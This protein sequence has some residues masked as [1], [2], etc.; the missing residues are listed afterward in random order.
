MG[1]NFAPIY[2]TLATP[3]RRGKL[4]EEYN[5]EYSGHFKDRNNNGNKTT[6]NTEVNLNTLL[7]FD[8]VHIN[9]SILKKKK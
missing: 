9:N 4:Y 1:T 7:H 2:A 3:F 6:T 8:K 5:Q